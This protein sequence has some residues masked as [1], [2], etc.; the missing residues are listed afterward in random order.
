MS[1][2]SD[3]EDDNALMTQSNA[4]EE[5]TNWRRNFDKSNKKRNGDYEMEI[6][7]NAGN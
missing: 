5:E 2:A 7:F 6:T 3:L 4:K 1:G